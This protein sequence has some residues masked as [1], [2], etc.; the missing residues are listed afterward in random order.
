MRVIKVNENE[1]FF[2]KTLLINLK[3]YEWIWIKT[4]TIE[5]EKYV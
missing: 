5:F 3:V 2:K 1:F 4:R